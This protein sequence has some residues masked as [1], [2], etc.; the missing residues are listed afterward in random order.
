MVDLIELV[1]TEDNETLLRKDTQH[2][3]RAK[4][5]GKPIIVSV[6]HRCF[7]E[8]KELKRIVNWIASDY[9]RD[10]PDRH[11]DANAYVVG[12]HSGA[13]S[14]YAVHPTNYY[15]FPVQFYKTDE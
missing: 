5:I 10:Y 12:D 4:S 7:S 14:P 2:K 15:E 6:H 13:P 3:I 8:G 1:F 9:S 11:R